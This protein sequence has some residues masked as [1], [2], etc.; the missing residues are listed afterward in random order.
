MKISPN[1]ACPCG[2][3]AKYKKCCRVLHVG[4]PAPTPEALMRSRYT[5][6]ALNNAAYIMETTHPNSPHYEEDK[7]QWRKTIENFIQH[8]RFAGLQILSAEGDTVTF[9]ATLFDGNVDI[10]YTER[11]VFRQHEDRWKYVDGSN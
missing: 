5:A 11:S 6:Y 7:I 8:T 1:D 4:N 9:H 10:S 3:G 2:S